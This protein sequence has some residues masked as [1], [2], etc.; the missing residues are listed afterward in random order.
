MKTILVNTLFIG[1]IVLVSCKKHPVSINPNPIT[2]A[3]DIVYTDFNNKLITQNPATHTYI[4]INNDG[5]IDMS[6][7][8]I[9]V[10]DFINKIDKLRFNVLTAINT[11]LP[12]NVNDDVPPLQKGDLIP[13][14]SFNAQDWYSAVEIT[15]IE[16]NEFV[17]GSIVWRGRWLGSNKLFLPFQITINGK[18]HTGWLQISE[19]KTNNAIILHQIAYCKTPEKEIKAGQ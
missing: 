4:D 15:V 16:R 2:P 18:R 8:T 13:L 19:D 5:K 3:T 11:A 10:G 12:V 7:G 14:E 1:C 17:N 6:L 9:L